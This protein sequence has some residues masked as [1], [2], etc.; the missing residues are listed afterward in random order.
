[1]GTISALVVVLLSNPPNLK[2]ADLSTRET[3]TTSTII[4]AGRVVGVEAEKRMETINKL[5]LAVK[6]LE[7]KGLTLSEKSKTEI[8]SAAYDIGKEVGIDPFFLIALSRMESDFLG[9]MQ[10]SPKC[11]MPGETFCHADCGITQHN[12][13][14]SRAW[15]KRECRTLAR[16]H[17]L[18][19][20]KSALEIK[21]HLEW[22]K[23][24]S[25][26]SWHKPYMRCVLNRYNQG[27]SYL[28]LDLCRSRRKEPWMTDQDY[29][30]VRK[31]CLGRAAYWMKL[32][33]FYHGAKTLKPLVR[34]CRYCFSLKSIPW[35]YGQPGSYELPSSL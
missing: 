32:L 10:L 35:Y 21:H 5:V 6:A 23:T 31:R 17:R 8:A 15:V 27:P 12:I 4:D 3:T 11:S 28:T 29:Q 25:H 18:A 14:G 20:R 13:H 34:S 24:K 2:V 26:Q 33:C 30:K 9:L 1:M 19:M 7:F 16:D 22:C